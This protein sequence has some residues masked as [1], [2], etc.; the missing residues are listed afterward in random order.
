MW[1]PGPRESVDGIEDVAARGEARRGH[2]RASRPAGARERNPGTPSLY[3][4]RWVRSWVRNGRKE[5]NLRP[6]SPEKLELLSS[7]GE[8]VPHRSGE[9][10]PPGG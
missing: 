4:C 3:A 7:S 1:M 5:P 9:N 8:S 6:E 10:V 2:A